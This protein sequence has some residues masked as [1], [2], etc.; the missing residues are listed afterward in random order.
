[1]TEYRL[2]VPEK[3]LPV[4]T[5]K[6]RFKILIGGRGSGKSV[7][8]AKILSARVAMEGIKVLGAREL[9]NSIE[10]S[11]HS[12]VKD[13][14]LT[15]GISGFEFQK[16]AIH[17]DNGGGF[18]YRGLSRNPAAVKSINQVDV[19]WVEEAQTLS[20][21]SIEMLTPSIRAAGSEIWMT[22]NPGSSK[23]PFSR[24]FIKPF[25][26]ELKAKGYYEDDMHLIIFVNYCDNPW[27]PPELE[28]ERQFDYENKSRAKYNHIWLGDYDDTVENAIILPEWFDACVDAH[29]KLGFEARGVEVVSHDPSDLGNDSKGL[30]YRHGVVFKDICEKQTGDINAGGDWAAD[31]ALS[32]KPDV[33]IW[34]G[35]GMGVGL[36]RQFNQ[37]FRDKMISL[38]MFQGS[39]GVDRPDEIYE[40]GRD[41][42]KKTNKQTFK[43]KRAQY[44]W[45]LRDRCYKTYQAV[46]KGKYIDPDELVSFASEIEA[47]DLLRSELCRIP[48]KDNGAGLIQI[49]SKKEMRKMGIESPNMADSAIISL[50]NQ[51]MVEYSDYNEPYYAS[52]NGW[53]S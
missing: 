38:Q 37:A 10:E 13:E 4:A 21:E 35:D 32:V 14:I 16:T 44:Y 45:D 11:V 40:D 31:Y 26:K 12:V 7:S 53:M 22:A 28:Q 3:I 34:D 47:I 19:A 5:K 8:V 48:L 46:K 52:E 29:I 2:E 27:F 43:N 39:A 25:E 6:K 49:M 9:M 24:R 17:H 1:M 15:T 23:D 50:A 42:Q 18:I 30:A 41:S 20:E 33:F 36:R 51:P